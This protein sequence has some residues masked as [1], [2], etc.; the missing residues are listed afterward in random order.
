MK[1]IDIIF[2]IISADVHI[3]SET[4]DWTYKFRSASFYRII[5]THR[6]HNMT[7]SMNLNLIL[8]VF[9][10]ILLMKEEC[11]RLSRQWNSKF[12]VFH[13]QVWTAYKWKTNKMQSVNQS[14][15]NDDYLMWITDWKQKMMTERLNLN[16]QRRSDLNLF[17]NLII[18]KFSDISREFRLTL[19]NIKNLKIKSQLTAAEKKILM[20]MLF[21]KK[22]TLF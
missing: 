16:L 11:A 17:S 12:N 5:S 9:R 20:T 3:V 10:L 21:N 13:H 8:Y 22:K 15:S 6:D 19:N 18:F 1:N 14:D 7:Q 2:T 4:A